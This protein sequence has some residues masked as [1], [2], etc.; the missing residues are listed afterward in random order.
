MGYESKFRKFLSEKTFKDYDAPKGQWTDI[1]TSDM[2]PEADEYDLTDE[3][4][5]LIATAYKPIGGHTN[6]KGPK[7]IPGKYDQWTAVD[8]DGDPEPDALRV[9]SSKPA[10]NKMTVAGHDGSRIAKDAYKDKTAD[11][12]KTQGYYAEMSSTV[13]H[14]MIAKYNVDY[15]SDKEAVEKVLGKEV[16]WVGAHPDGKYP[17]YDGWYTRTIGGK[18]S[19]MKILLGKPNV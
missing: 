16:Q 12:L 15:V 9:A 18:D 17:G 7:D 1:P 14:I 13:A 3:L 10:G 19:H 11:L 8:L 4:Y 5:D 6:I 2:S